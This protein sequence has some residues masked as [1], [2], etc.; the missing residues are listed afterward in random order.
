VWD[1]TLQH[2]CQTL[3]GFKGEVWSLAV[4]PDETRVVAG[5]VDSDLRVYSVRNPDAAAGAAAAAGEQKAG[6]QTAA[7]AAA[8]A[9]GSE[10][11]DEGGDV[12]MAELMT[13]Q[14]QQQQKVRQ[15]D[16]LQFMGLVRRTGQERVGLI[17]YD[18]K[19]ELLG[20]M[21]AG[22]GL[23]VFRWGLG[24]RAAERFDDLAFGVV[25]VL[26]CMV[27]QRHVADVMIASKCFNPKRLHAANCCCIYS[28]AVVL[29]TYMTCQ[30]S[31]RTR[32]L[33]HS[34]LCC[35][36]QCAD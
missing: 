35:S 13:G 11:E 3:I 33:M 15:H 20:V 22:K 34:S 29:P 31:C 6:D 10:S 36:V 12:R 1:V 24:F 17:R 25:W 16:V 32:L 28:T 21:G 4:N 14:Q 9:A 18:A 8:A 5:C 7:A 30:L 27:Q 26:L 23:E 19:G 2:C